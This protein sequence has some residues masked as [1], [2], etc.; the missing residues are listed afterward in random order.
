MC[1]LWVVSVGVVFPQSNDIGA[2]IRGF[3]FLSL[4][5]SYPGARNDAEL[6]V[7]RVT[8][9]L[10]FGRKAEIEI[11]GVIDF[12]SPSAASNNSLAL[13][14]S[15]YF[16]PLQFDLAE[17][18]DYYS[19]ARLDRFNFSFDAGSTS[20][21]IGRQPVT[22]GEGYFWPALD[23]FAPFA[24][25]QIDRDYKSGV[26][27]VKVNIP[28]GNL[29]ELEFIG[30]ILG[31]SMK[32]DG[33]A[34]ALLRWNLGNVDLGF[35]GGTFHQD[36]VGGAFVSADVRG[37][38]IRGEISF[39]SS[40]DS[41]DLVRGRES[42][43]RGSA[44]LLRQLTPT[45]TLTSEFAFNGYG[46]DRPEDYALWYSSDRM[47][48]GEVNGYGRYYWGTSLTRQLHP[49]LIGTFT[50]LVNFTDRSVLV[51][52][53]LAWSV[54][55]NADILAGGELSVGEGLR[56]KNGEQVM[57]SEYGAVPATLFLALKMYF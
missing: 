51:T 22:W 4:E 9:Y 49:L 3:Q 1:A 32:R 7:L 30:G 12:S 40:G 15:R 54:S 31:N 52:P 33:T 8:D 50:S 24:P 34:G 23:L 42:F 44:G 18:E 21:T 27:T 48:R 43:W 38:G 46:A 39:T 41:L 57:G 36:K 5:D 26:D 47:R 17:D 56:E 11:H 28:L 53:S 20:I 16:L 6:A 25:E 29:S 13:S 2:S 45:L 37:T 35:M 55:N 10:E 14:R 19:E